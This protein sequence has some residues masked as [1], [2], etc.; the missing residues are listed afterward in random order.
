MIIH[1]K[2]VPLYDLDN[3]K[4]FVSMVT[5]NK[6]MAGI[7]QH[8]LLYQSKYATSWTRKDITLKSDVEFQVYFSIF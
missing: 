1:Y 3:V 4:L 2:V 7:I 6:D 5:K 8:K